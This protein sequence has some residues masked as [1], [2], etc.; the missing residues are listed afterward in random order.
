V[1]ERK[2]LADFGRLDRSMRLQFQIQSLLE[3]FA[4]RGR[5][6]RS[7]IGE[8]RANAQPGGCFKAKMTFPPNYPLY[9]PKMKFETPIFHPNGKLSRTR[10]LK[11]Q[12]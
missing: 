12:V 7:N 2:V 11:A 1:G 6:S 5:S 10:A 8:P 9:P 4:R 3:C